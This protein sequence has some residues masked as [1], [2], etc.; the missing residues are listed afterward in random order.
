MAD[1]AD[2]EL[3]EDDAPHTVPLAG[4]LR[5]ARVALGLSQEATASRLGV[6]RA[7][8]ARWERGTLAPPE[9]LVPNILEVLGVRVA[10]S[11]TN[12]QAIPALHRERANG[13][14]EGTLGVG[15]MPFTYGDARRVIELPAY[16]TNGPPNQRPFH[17]ALVELQQRGESANGEWSEYRRRLSLVAVADGELTA[18]AAL[19]MPSSAAVSWNSNYGSH[20]WHRYVGRFPP[21]VVRA[22]LNAFGAGPG[23]LVL[24]PF[25][26]SGTTLVECRLLG[27]PALGIEISP[28]S[29]LLSRTKAGFPD[30]G[31]SLRKLANSLDA[32]FAE[33]ELKGVM[34][35]PPTHAAVLARPGNL[36][37]E[38]P[39]LERWFTI[40]AL[41]GVSLTTEFAARFG[42]Y[43]RDALLVALS[44]KM[45]SIGNVD[46]DVVRAEYRKEAR[47]NVDVRALVSNH[48][49]KMAT[50]IDASLSS[51]AGLIG[52]PE[53]IVV[54]EGDV[55]AVSI[56]PGS[57]SHII[58]SPPYGVESL[59]YF[60]THLLSFRTLEPFLKQ[61]PYAVG[62]GVIGS[63]YLDDG[64][65]IVSFPRAEQSEAYQRF[66]GDV[67]IANLSPNERR[68]MTMMMKFFDDMALVAERF[69]AW[70]VPGGRVAFVIGNKKLGERVI[71]T[72]EVVRE[73][74]ASQGLTLDRELRHKLKTNNSNSVVPWQE[75]VI[76]DEYVLTFRNVG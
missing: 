21:H 17:E 67:D 55:L 19:E 63:E 61:D 39:N 38:F 37:P 64:S 32:F 23:D 47:H 28:L 52:R 6:G 45:R 27:I 22:L 24:D 3:V 49:A 54:K 11:E 26:G 73:L 41:L 34:E 66:F 62:K 29:A 30:D 2:T 31:A 57:V 15:R 60:R 69:S 33:M 14:G 9:E 48:L 10:H 1:V 59:S 40:E 12:A 13:D 42:G 25:A 5:E 71:P 75:R 43:E 56:E 58:T 53:S 36:V 65:E 44:A 18:Q 46:V 74:F 76:S 51:H 68:R 8:V 70:L 16:V 50:S 20:G 72:A 7:T 4:R 35:A